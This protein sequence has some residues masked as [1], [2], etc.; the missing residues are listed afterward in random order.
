MRLADYINKKILE[1]TGG[2]VEYGGEEEEERVLLI[3][4]KRKILEDK[5]REY[6][7][8]YEGDSDELLNYYTVQTNI[9]YN[10]EPIYSRNKRGYFWSISSTEND[11][12]R[13]HSGQPRNIVD[14]LTSIIGVPEIYAGMKELS[15]GTTNDTLT[16]VLE[17]NE[18]W[19]KYLFE[20]VPMTLVEGWGCWKIDWDADISDKPEIKYYRAKDVEFIYQDKR[21]NGIIFKDYYTDGKLRSY[22]IT[23]TRTV[24]KGNLYIF[25]EVFR[26]T[27]DEITPVNSEEVPGLSGIE[28][29]PIVIEHFNKFLAVPCVFYNDTSNNDGYGRSIFTGKI[30]LFD[31]LDQCLSQESN[32][33]RRSTPIE[34]FNTDFL[35]RDPVTKLPKM[36]K[37]YDRKYTSFIGGRTADGTQT[38]TQ[39]VQVT[40][41]QLQFGEYSNEAQAILMQAIAGIISPATMGIDVAKKDNA[42]AQR[43]KEKITIFTRNVIIKAE[44][45]ILKKLFNQ[46]LIAVQMMR[47]GITTC[48]DYAISVK[49]SEFAD[50]SFENKLQKLGEAY[51]KGTLSTDMYL[52]K[53]YGDSISGS[54][55]AKEKEYLE[56]HME[57]TNGEGEVG[58]N[59]F[60]AMMGGDDAAVQGE[61]NQGLDFGDEKPGFKG[62]EPGE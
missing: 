62:V 26:I 3:N 55:R 61:D 38:A 8:W 22:L 30:D 53:L 32:T 39:P 41:P 36:P 24:K 18:F 2:L 9:D 40:Q 6:N 50:E 13:T 4:D 12:K 37:V 14:T 54:E 15:I 28:F 49:Y 21:L 42:D 45:R 10:Y 33:V 58:E 27:S 44:T 46:I 23:E 34:Y 29:D 47:E 51:I 16:S 20:Q 11:I 48:M 60:A 56:K 1:I 57:A 43:E 17:E 59:P 5:L 25:K 35:E 52:D 31:D 19:E 7:V